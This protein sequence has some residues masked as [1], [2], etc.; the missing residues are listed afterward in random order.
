MICIYLFTVALL[1]AS[2]LVPS[3]VM[4]RARQSFRQRIR[5]NPDL[6]RAVEDDLASWRA[7][8]GNASY[9]PL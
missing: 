5:A 2:I 6:R 7:A 4:G 9:G 1:V 8:Y 3:V